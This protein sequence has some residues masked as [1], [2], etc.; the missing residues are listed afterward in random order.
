MHLLGAKRQRKEHTGGGEPA[1][2]SAFQGHVLPH[3]AHNRCTGAAARPRGR[4]GPPN[5]SLGPAAAHP[6]AR[7]GMPGGTRGSSSRSFGRDLPNLPAARGARAPAP[8]L[9]SSSGQSSPR[10]LPARSPPRPGG[11]WPKV[12]RPARPGPARPGSLARLRPPRPRARTGVLPAA[13]ARARA[14][15]KREGSERPRR[16]RAPP[17]PP[18]PTRR[19]ARIARPQRPWMP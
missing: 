7:W 15:A 11:R 18:T 1:S 6:A 19:T 13:R 8:P 17:P 5:L 3:L 2:G 10:A 9:C 14:R 12:P 4:P 16:P